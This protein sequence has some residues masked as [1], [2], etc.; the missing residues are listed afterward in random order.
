MALNVEKCH[1][2]ME[3]LMQIATPRKQAQY[4]VDMFQ[5]IND[6]VECREVISTKNV[7][8]I[9]QPAIDASKHAEF[10]ALGCLLSANAISP[11]EMHR[12]NQLRSQ[13]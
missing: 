8:Y 3:N 9:L 5:T 2:Q 4:V 13:V 11:A 7:R 1:E 12:L 6:A 10:A